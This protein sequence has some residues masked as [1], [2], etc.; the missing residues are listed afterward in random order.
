MNTGKMF[1]SV[2]WCP[3]RHRNMATWRNLFVEALRA[4]TKNQVAKQ[5]QHSRTSKL[6]KLMLL[7]AGLERQAPN[8]RA[9]ESKGL[10]CERWDFR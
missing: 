1:D 3:A 5:D 7:L 2:S 8:F 10:H 9:F 6:R 4:H